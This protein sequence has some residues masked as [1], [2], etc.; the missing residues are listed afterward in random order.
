MSTKS[1]SSQKTTSTTTNIQ[2]TL[3]ASSDGVVVGDLLQGESISVSNQ[4]PDSVAKAFG[5]LIELTGQTVDI[6]AAAGSRAISSGETSLAIVAKKSEIETAPEL[7]TLTKLL[8]TIGLGIAA[9]T[10]IF[11][12]KRG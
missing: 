12:F 1:K 5:Q 10:L 3:Q 6:A 11:I 8:P 9:I 2:E 4:F 7:A